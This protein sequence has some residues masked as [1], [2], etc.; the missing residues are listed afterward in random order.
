MMGRVRNGF[1]GRTAIDT[2]TRV[3]EINQPK[4]DPTLTVG[5]HMARSE[6]YRGVVISEGY[7]C[8]AGVLAETA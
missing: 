4:C 1:K 8:E 6:Q 3:D 2:G 5:E 7:A